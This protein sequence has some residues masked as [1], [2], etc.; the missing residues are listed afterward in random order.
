L[1]LNIN[2]KIMGPVVD[3]LNRTVART[4]KSPHEIAN[5]L[6]ILHPEILFTPED[7]EQLPPKTQTG[8]INRIR[9]TLESFA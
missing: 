2:S 9:T 1:A 8:I 3:E 7:W 4:G 6:S 5:T